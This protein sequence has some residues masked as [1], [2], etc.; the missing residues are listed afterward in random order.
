MMTDRSCEESPEYYEEF[1][2]TAF[3]FQS[4]EY[5]DPSPFPQRPDRWY[6][7]SIMGNGGKEKTLFGPNGR[8]RSLHTKITSQETPGSQL[9]GQHYRHVGDLLSQFFSFAILDPLIEELITLDN[10]RLP[11]A[12]NEAVCIVLAAVEMYLR[13]HNRTILKEDVIAE[14]ASEFGLN[15]TRK[16]ISAAKWSLAK[17]G[18]WKEHLY[19][20]NTATYDILRNLTL[21]IITNFQFPE[22]EV[23]TAFRRQLYHRC[24]TLIDLIQENARRPQILEA[25]AHAVA[26]IAAEEILGLSVLTSKDIG[27]STF[28]T[29]VYRAKRQISQLIPEKVKK[30]SLAVPKITYSQFSDLTKSQVSQNLPLEAIQTAWEQSLS[31]KTIRDKGEGLVVEQ[32]PIE[33]LTCK[34]P[35]IS[36]Q[37][38][39]ISNL[40]CATNSHSL[41][42][43]THNVLFPARMDTGRGPPL[44]KSISASL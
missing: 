24:I 1:C 19:D 36:S 29:S 32:L 28:N 30:E 22:R 9:R 17:A 31:F 26:S 10:I 8:L 18:F 11:R 38:A 4:T 2:T 23:L 12:T 3:Q 15:V 39:E 34:E 37:S 13:K 44:L 14:I 7:G 42:S 41:S 21:E 16:K 35:A 40:F 5:Q 33:H 20:I 27:D 6:N 43:A 25:Y